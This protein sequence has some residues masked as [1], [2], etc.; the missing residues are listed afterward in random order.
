LKKKTF[1]ISERL[2]RRRRCSIPVGSTTFG[3][4]LFG[5]KTFG[6]HKSCAKAIFVL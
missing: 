6:L 5:R 2:S 3:R 1:F 4:K